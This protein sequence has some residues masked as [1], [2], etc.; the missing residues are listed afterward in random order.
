MRLII[1]SF[2][3]TFSSFNLFS[4]CDHPDY[5]GL[6]EIYHGNNGENWKLNTGWKEGAEN[7]SCNPCDFNG[8]TWQYVT[9]INDR[10]VGLQ[11][12]FENM[13][14]TIPDLKLSELELINMQANDLTGSI[15]NFSHSPNLKHIELDF[16]DLSGEIPAFDFC[17]NLEFLE[18]DE[19]CLTGRLPIFKSKKLQKI[20]IDKNELTG[21]VPNYNLPDLTRLLMSDNNFSG[22]V[23]ACDSMPKLRAIGLGNNNLVGDNPDFP[24]CPEMVIGL[25][26]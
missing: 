10:V 25:F 17:E 4:Q 3:F 1:A 2:L 24:F 20:H 13:T 7:I 19:N 22:T 6:M 23:P 14:G 9:C 16:N 8:Q 12:G 26:T 11:I 21:P 5:E 15:P 18:L